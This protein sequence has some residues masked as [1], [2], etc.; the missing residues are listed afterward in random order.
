MAGVADL[1]FQSLNWILTDLEGGPSIE[2]QFAPTSLTEN[3][4]AQYA[5]TATL[6]RSQPILQ[7]QGNGPHTVTFDAKLW[8][9]SQGVLGL[10]SQTIEDAIDAIKSTVQIDPD[11]GRP[12]IYSFNAGETFVLDSC[13]VTSVGGIRYDRMRPLDGSHRGVTFSITL[14]EFV[15]YDTSLT[16]TGAESLVLALREN[17]GF[18]NLARRVYGDPTPGEALRRR[19]PDKVVPEVGDLIHLPAKPKLMLGFQLKPQNTTLGSSTVALARRREIFRE[20]DRTY[21]LFAVDWG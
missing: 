7:F 20:K 17:E 19:N 10:G 2:G 14:Q 6:A 18:E 4:V 5:E 21:T 15:P 8:A 16:G 12:H 9:Y 3:M 1:L 11:L 13:V